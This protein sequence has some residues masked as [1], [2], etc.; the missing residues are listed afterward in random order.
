MF[1]VNKILCENKLKDMEVVV[2]GHS[3]GVTVAT[4]VVIKLFI[5]LKQ[6]CQERSVKCVTFGAP[7]IGDRA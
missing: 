5:C 7:L 1:P 4:I 2:C 6:F 3:L